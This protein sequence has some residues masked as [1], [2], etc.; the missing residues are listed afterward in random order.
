MSNTF[1]WKLNANRRCALY[2][3]DAAFTNINI[4]YINATDVIV[5]RNDKTRQSKLL[6]LYD[7]SRYI[8]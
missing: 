4:G 1:P 5:S 8:I 7:T 6:K 2:F 3:V